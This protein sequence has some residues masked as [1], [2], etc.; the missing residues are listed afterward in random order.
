MT[1]SPALPSRMTY[2]VQRPECLMSCRNHSLFRLVMT[3]DPSS[4]G[5]ARQ[6]RAPRD[7]GR[8]GIS[9]RHRHRTRLISRG[10][11]E[12]YDEIRR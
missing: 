7:C 10:Q 5:W 1:L 2:P 9:Q 6:T 3:T 12:H 11:S 8:R 4:I